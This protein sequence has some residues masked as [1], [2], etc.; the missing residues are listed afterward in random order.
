[1]LNLL[2]KRLKNEKGLTL[3]EV[4][5]G[6]CYFSNCCSNCVF[7]QSGILLKIQVYKAV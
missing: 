1:M 2:K 7:Q 3:V 5:S 6:S 4:I